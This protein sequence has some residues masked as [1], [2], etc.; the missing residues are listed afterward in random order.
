MSFSRIL[1]RADDILFD[2]YHLHFSKNNKCLANLLALEA[3]PFFFL[4]IPIAFALSNSSLKQNESNLNTH[5]GVTF[6]NSSGMRRFYL[7]LLLLLWGQYYMKTSN[8][9]SVNILYGLVRHFKSTK[10]FTW[11]FWRL[12]NPSSI[13]F[14]RTESM[15]RSFRT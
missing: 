5:L 3:F 14:D 9:H 11:R 10:R 7:L 15:A 8:I 12:F 2:M 6:L 1:S 4:M 13:S